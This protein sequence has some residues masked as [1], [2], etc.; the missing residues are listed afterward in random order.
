MADKSKGGMIFHNPN[1]EVANLDELSADESGAGVYVSYD[2]V[3]GAQL[4]QTDASLM[5]TPNT[6]SGDG[7]MGGPASGEPNPNKMKPTC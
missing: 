3:I 2:E 6:M 5:S 1:N 7:L 4:S